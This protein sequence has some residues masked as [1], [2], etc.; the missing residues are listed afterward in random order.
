[1][2]VR[3]S[4]LMVTI[5]IL[6]W[7]GLFLTF[8]FAGALPPELAASLLVIEALSAF[9]MTI[10]SIITCC[11][12]LH[13]NARP[14]ESPDQ[15]APNPSPSPRGISQSLGRLHI[16]LNAPLLV[17]FND[18]LLGVAYPITQDEHSQPEPEPPVEIADDTRRLLP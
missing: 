15:E 12:R 13:Q 18:Q 17:K 14:P 5:T 1:M 9:V 7:I 6:F 11:L 16:N 10:T 3:A 2:N 8:L 4:S